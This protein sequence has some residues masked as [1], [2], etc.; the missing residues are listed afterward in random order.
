MS[1]EEALID[2][3]R[4]LLRMIDKVQSRQSRES[5]YG[6][7][8]PAS[9]MG[10]QVE[11]VR[12]ALSRPSGA[13]AEADGDVPYWI[14]ALPEN[15]RKTTGG[16]FVG[17]LPLHCE[18][19]EGVHGDRCQHCDRLWKLSRVSEPCPALE[20]VRIGLIPDDAIAAFGCDIEALQVADGDEAKPCKRW[21][22]RPECPYTLRT[23][24]AAPPLPEPV[25]VAPDLVPVA[26]R[27]RWPNGV[28]NYQEGKQVIPD[29]EA[30]EAL[31]RLSDHA[32]ALATLSANLDAM[33]RERDEWRDNWDANVQEMS[34]K[35]RAVN[36]SR[37]IEQS[38]SDIFALRERAETAE[39]EVARLRNENAALKEALVA[40]ND[41]LRGAFGAAQRDAIHEVTGTTNYN[42]L[43]NAIQKVL[44]KYH[45]ITNDARALLPA[46]KEG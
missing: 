7:Y 5:V 36:I 20:K 29:L 44:F 39:A 19:R 21:C 3:M 23:E 11:K 37:V 43:A 2:D 33:R 35:F 34:E 13:D 9:Q 18:F 14:A 26:W 17:L 40:H 22:R 28:W 42:L 32:N 10:K 6:V 16:Q 38:G 30:Q 4:E 41:L 15:M 8:N 27:W 25:A 46:K 31:I 1:K 12:A 24:P 45:A